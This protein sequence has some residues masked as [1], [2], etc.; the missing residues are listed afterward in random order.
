[1][2]NYENYSNSDSNRNEWREEKISELFSYMIKSLPILE[3]TVKR[4]PFILAQE[5]Q[6]TIDVADNPEFRVIMGDAGKDELN[7]CMPTAILER[8]LAVVT[9]RLFALYEEKVVADYDKPVLF[10]G[11][12]DE[13][14]FGHS[15]D[16]DRLFAQFVEPRFL[17]PHLDIESKEFATAN[18][19]A[20]P[21]E[22]IRAR[23]YDP[24]TFFDQRFDRAN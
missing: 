5:F 3:S 1:M 12:F 4:D 19:F 13:F 14:I 11:Y 17:R 23:V 8:R 22:S 16:K 7:N 2:T 21:V 6:K 10:S 24:D 9:N 15:D 20:I 18:T